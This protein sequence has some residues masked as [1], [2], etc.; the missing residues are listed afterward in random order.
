MRQH[1]SGGAA[2]GGQIVALHVR[3]DETVNGAE[4][5]SSD[6]RRGLILAVDVSIDSV[7]V[8]DDDV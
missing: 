8:L 4:G 3:V 2:S 1:K 5:I 7:V 6:P